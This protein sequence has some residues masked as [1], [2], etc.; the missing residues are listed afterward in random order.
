MFHN[1]TI[2]SMEYYR[3]FGTAYAFLVPTSQILYDWFEEFLVLK[4]SR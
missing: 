2:F 3:I 1:T 4:S